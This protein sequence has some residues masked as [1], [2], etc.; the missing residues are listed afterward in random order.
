MMRMMG[1]TLLAALA[2][3]TFT[4]CQESEGSDAALIRRAR[5]IGNENLQLKKQ[6]EEKEEKIAQLRQQIQQ[7][8]TEMNEAARQAG[9]TN[10]R[11]MQIVK[12]KK[13]RN[14]Q[15]AEENAKLKA[16]LEQLKDEQPAGQ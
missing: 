2:V 11:I 6:L 3:L 13:K 5:L 8:Q 9:E 15:L 7:L 1:I 10:L 16:Q 12:K 14:Q 4:G